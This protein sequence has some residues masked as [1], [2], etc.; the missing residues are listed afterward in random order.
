MS[1]PEKLSIALLNYCNKN[2]IGELEKVLEKNFIPVKTKPKTHLALWDTQTKTYCLLVP[3]P[4]L[5]QAPMK[6]ENAAATD[7]PHAELWKIAGIMKH[8]K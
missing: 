1:Q 6:M 3:S 5:T 7:N 2:R 4:N 8:S